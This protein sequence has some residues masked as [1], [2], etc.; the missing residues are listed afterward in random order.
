MST[1][2]SQMAH[3]IFSQAMRRTDPGG[4]V[5]KQ[6][7]CDGTTLTLGNASIPLNELERLQIVAMG[8]AAAPMY[9]AAALLLRGTGLPFEGVVVAPEPP[10][11]PL[12]HG[13]FHAG[14][15][16]TPDR[17]SLRAAD[18]VLSLLNTVTGRSAVLFLVSGGA[19]AMLERPLDPRVSLEDAAAFHRALVGSGLAIGQMNALRK[20]FSAVK[21]GR[22]AQA[23]AQ[24]RAQCTLLISDVPPGEL[25]TI[26]SGPT[27]PDST[28]LA[29]CRELLA[30]IRGSLPASVV[31]Y[32]DGPLC[33]ETPKAGDEAFARASWAAV[34]SSEDLAAAAHAAGQ[35]AGFHVE[36]DNTCDEWEYRE[37]ARHLLERSAVLARRHRR[38]CLIS[39]G[40]ISVAIPGS[41]GEGGRNQ[42]FALWSAAELARS[43]Q[44]ATVLSAGSD[45]IDGN[46]RAA[47]AVCDETTVAR[48]ERLGLHVEDALADFNSGPLL[49]AVGD[50]IVTGPTGNN[51]RD[52]R[53]V[54]TEV[55]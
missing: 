32:F 29:E 7:G 42:Q 28:T 22:L 20:H 25:D 3:N 2:L 33:V 44:R 27:L 54:L 18:A 11:E 40:E 50:D 43:G 39:V 51:V 36:I 35:V 55:H 48:A 37:A 6:I 30:K 16:P 12:E 17:R 41:A 38:S 26:G 8:K 31:A 5:G 24:A 1:F 45:G 19:S 47:G 10:L 52:L 23:A 13:T 34:L 53:M 9:R 21:G 4:A 46:S 49:R 14:A 15:H